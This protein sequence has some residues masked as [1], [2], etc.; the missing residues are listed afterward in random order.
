MRY[1]ARG[2]YVFDLINDLIGEVTRQGMGGAVDM[3][4]RNLAAQ[5]EGDDRRAKEREEQKKR[6]IRLRKEAKYTHI[7]AMEAENAAAE[8]K[9]REEEEEARGKKG[10]MFGGMGGGMFG[11]KSAGGGGG[12]GAAKA[13]G[14]MFGWGKKS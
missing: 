5:A 6:N 9:L 7:K 11:S 4:S 12:G 10:G 1:T 13:L 3:F 2:G 14:S 8:A